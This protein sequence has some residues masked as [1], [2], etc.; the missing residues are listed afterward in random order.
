MPFDKLYVKIECTVCKGTRTF[1]GG[2]HDPM[3]PFMW[4]TCPYCDEE[5]KMLIEAAD[6]TII[7]FFKSISTE[8]TRKILLEIPIQDE[9]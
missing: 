8:R 9:I 3:R 1:N 5:G 2:H 7:E 6:S 4:K